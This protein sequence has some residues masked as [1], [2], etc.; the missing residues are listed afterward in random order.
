[1]KSLDLRGLKSAF[2]GLCPLPAANRR[3]APLSNPV[4]AQRYRCK[5]RLLPLFIVYNYYCGITA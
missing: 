4:Y 2:S 5:N 1:L 3:P